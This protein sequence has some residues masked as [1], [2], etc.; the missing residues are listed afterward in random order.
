MYVYVF[1][2]QTVQQHPDGPTPGDLEMIADGTLQ[3]FKVDS[4]TEINEFGEEEDL[5]DCEIED[6]EPGTYHVPSVL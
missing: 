1:E 5:E 4:I 2:D 3:V 6:L